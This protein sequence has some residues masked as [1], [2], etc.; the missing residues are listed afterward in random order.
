VLR[1]AHLLAF[2]TLLA[3]CGARSELEVGES[4][5]EAPA[6][7]CGDGRV[8]P[9][10]TCDDAGRADGGCTDDCRLE[11]CGNGML[12]EGEVCDKGKANEDR[13]ALGVIQGDTLRA[14]V[15]HPIDTTPDVFYS[16]TSK[17]AHTGFEAVRT[18]RLFYTH[19]PGGLA[20][21]T[22][23]GIDAD[24]TGVM[25]RKGIV[26]QTFSGLPLGA[27]VV[28]ADDGA[29]E[30]YSMGALTIHGHWAFEGNTDGGTLGPLPFPGTWT[31]EVVTSFETGIDAW[32]IL[33]DTWAYESAPID[34]DAQEPAYLVAY[35]T[36]SLCRRD[37]SIPRCGDGRL[38]GGEVCDDENTT[39][40]DG[41]RA[42]CKA[43][44]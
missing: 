23:H 8:D 6:A 40:G 10:E 15:P 21:T 42:D 29:Q 33:G 17:S 16:Y 4:I 22:L 13:P 1:S 3:S 18:S 5:E 30:F 12:D 9:G 44:D 37:C 35:E 26:E 11:T 20:L 39:S 36:P 19:G 32:Q 38:D 25:Q 34:L 41:C 14:L 27:G 2:S 24:S 28:V 31:I 7:R 43:R